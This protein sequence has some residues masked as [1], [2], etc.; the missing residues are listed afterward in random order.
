MDASEAKTT[1]SEMGMRS[2]SDKT[3]EEDKDERNMKDF[4]APSDF[5]TFERNRGPSRHILDN[6][7]QHEAELLRPIQISLSE[8]SSALIIRADVPGIKEKDLKINVEPGRVTIKRRLE[9]KTKFK[10]IEADCSESFS[11]EMRRVINLP[12]A[13]TVNKVTITAEDGVLE[14]ELAKVEP[15]M[16]QQTKPKR[17]SRRVCR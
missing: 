9:T 5:G 13:V 1:Q 8:S 14:L 15:T 6:W 4:V 3:I 17:L 2:P 12:E 10:T 7:L 16:H 11:D